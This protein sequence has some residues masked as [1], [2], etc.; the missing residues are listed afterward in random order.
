MENN[1]NIS[2]T[3][4]VSLPKS[5]NKVKVETGL[6]TT[7]D[8]LQLDKDGKFLF[9]ESAPGKFVELDRSTIN[10][11]SERNKIS[12]LSALGSNRLERESVKTP[13]TPNLSVRPA[14]VMA[15]MK[16]EVTGKNPAWHYVWKRPDELHTATAEGY[17]EVDNSGGEKSF[18]KDFTG[19]HVVGKEG[20]E[21][22][23]LMAT[24]Q[25]NYKARLRAISE[26]SRRFDVANTEG[27]KEALERLGGQPFEPK[28]DSMEE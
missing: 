12:Y 27:A 23:I 19:R 20:H 21:D 28:F 15:G 6:Q 7:A 14:I 5:D 16:L 3:S 11:L 9:F 26:K 2:K 8:I 1:V 22:L 24:T 10:K 25:E 17:W 4:K 18:F 13:Q